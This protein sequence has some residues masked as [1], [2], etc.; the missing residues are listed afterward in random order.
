[1]YANI[2]F[3][4]YIL[5]ALGIFAKVLQQ[6]TLNHLFLY[7]LEFRHIFLFSIVFSNMLNRHIGIRPLSHHMTISSGLVGI[8]AAPKPQN[9]ETLSYSRMT[10]CHNPE[11]NEKVH[12]VAMANVG[13]PR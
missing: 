6:K 7:L 11:K 1:M 12:A 3:V 10:K 13:Y 5:W 2:Q 4:Q 8:T 9:C